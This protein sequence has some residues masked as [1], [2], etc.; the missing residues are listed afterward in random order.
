MPMT[1]LFVLAAA[2]ASAPMPLGNPGTWVTTADYPA[3]A[4]REGREGVVGFALDIG[5]DGVPVAC[6]ITQSS[7][8]PA[9][10]E[11]TCVLTRERARFRAASDATGKPVV[12]QFA[13]RVRWEIP[14]TSPQPQSGGMT[15]SFVV[16][17]DGMFGD[18][19]LDQISGAAA[20][21]ARMPTPCDQGQ[22][23]TPYLDEH[24]VP[25]ARKITVRQS[26]SVEPVPA[27]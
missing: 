22:K 19:K 16:R 18:C 10:D 21:M 9:L 6:R 4:L 2:A 20:A 13:S 14:K 24:G 8:L 5:T 27:P 7:G 12:G 26:I 11:A 1:A 3:D 15:M 17:P 25:V 23:T